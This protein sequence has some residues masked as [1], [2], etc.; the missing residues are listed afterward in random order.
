[1]AKKIRITWEKVRVHTSKVLTAA[2]AATMLAAPG[3][4]ARAAFPGA[5]GKIAFDS[6]RNGNFE[7]FAM[8]A[9][10]SD[11]VNLTRNPASDSDPGVVVGR[12]VRRLHLR[13]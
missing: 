1:M 12:P 7:V 6:F 8:D 11:P 3:A 2:I 10:G 5:N 9:D 13:P 4:P